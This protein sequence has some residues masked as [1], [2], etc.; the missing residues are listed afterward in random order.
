MSSQQALR[1]ALLSSL[2]VA[3]SS[4]RPADTSAA[5]AEAAVPSRST[6]DGTPAASSAGSPGGAG[7][8]LG[9]SAAPGAGS[10][11]ASGAGSPVVPAAGSLAASGAEP[12]TAL[13]EPT[14]DAIAGVLF[15]DRASP[16][17]AAASCPPSTP[18]DARVR[19]L[20]D[21]RYRG[22]A[23]AAGLAHELFVK[24]R[25]VAG[26]EVA[27]TMNGGYRGM[28]RLEPAVPTGAERKHLEWIVTAMRDFDDSFAALDRRAAGAEV[29]RSKRFRFEPITL[30]F[31]RSVAART[32][33]A[34]AHDWT[35]AWN[36]AGS[37][38]RSADAVRETLFHEIFHLNDYAHPPPGGE[39]WSPS[40]LGATFDAV[41]K[42]CGTSIACLGP[43]SPNDTIVRGGTYYSFQPGNG[44]REYAAELAVRYYREQRAELRGSKAES[45]TGRPPAGAARFKCG[46]PENARAWALMRDEFFGGVDVVPACGS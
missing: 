24:W 6:S 39:A 2:V 9:G 16:S 31:M 35:V 15:A 10:S 43:Y 5:T 21:L 23:K 11:A 29:S 13:A 41:V 14:F 27:H 4:Q 17:A 8:A 40:A 46:P 1:A 18:P 42:K 3:C 34:Y 20:F 26:V 30:R 36:L 33:S 44:V 7:S 28:I 32:P 37:L 22:D 19:C 38:H 25:V 45:P 12:R